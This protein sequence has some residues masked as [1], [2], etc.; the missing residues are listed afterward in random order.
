MP[1]TKD[2]MSLTDLVIMKNEDEATHIPSFD[3]HT[4]RLP[5]KDGEKLVVQIASNVNPLD[6]GDY[7]PEAPFLEV[8]YQDGAL[9][10]EWIKHD[11]D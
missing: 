3:K 5:K 7:D 1:N 9:T 6:F 11:R 2:A 8:T 4:V 10:F